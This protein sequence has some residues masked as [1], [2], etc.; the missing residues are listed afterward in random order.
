MKRTVV[1]GSIDLGAEPWH[2]GSEVRVTIIFS[3]A[4]IDFRQAEV[5]DV[6]NL[7]LSTFFG[8]SQVV[9]PEGLPVTLEGFTLFGGKE[10][11]RHGKKPSPE[12]KRQL[13][14]NSTN[15]F[16]GVTVSDRP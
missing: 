4:R 16:G 15:V 9:I 10:V 3:S 11:K 14:I 7:R 8:S 13:N 12:D 2:P 5:E 1:F 6:T